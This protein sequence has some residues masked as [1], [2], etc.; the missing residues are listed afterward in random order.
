MKRKRPSLEELRGVKG[1]IAGWICLTSLHNY[2]YNN[3][4]TGL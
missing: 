2:M 1:L 3:P 4:V